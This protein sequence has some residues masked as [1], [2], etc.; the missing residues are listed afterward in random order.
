MRISESKAINTVR[1]GTKKARS[2]ASGSLFSLAEAAESRQISTRSGVSSS[3]M[4]GDISTLLAIQGADQDQQRLVAID[5]GFET[6]DALDELKLDVLSG[7]V[8]RRKLLHLAAIVEKQRSG[9]NDPGLMKVLDHIELR[10]RVE[11]AKF[12][13]SRVNH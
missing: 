10:A 11:L 9:L 5:R 6:L 3:S 4:I 8:S 7:S 1:K 2:G 12:E 13:R